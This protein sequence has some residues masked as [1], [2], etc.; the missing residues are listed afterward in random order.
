M[1]GAI[2]AGRLILHHGQELL[3]AA[4]STRVL[5]NWY[6]VLL[7]LLVPH[8][9]LPLWQARGLSLHLLLRGKVRWRVML[10]I[11]ILMSCWLLSVLLRLQ[12]TL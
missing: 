8:T 9:V 3:Q 11:R 10:L 6:F 2:V 7:L 5:R 1:G 4:V 12:Q